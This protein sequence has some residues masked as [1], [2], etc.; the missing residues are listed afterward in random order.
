[1]LLHGSL[2]TSFVCACCL[3]RCFVKFEVVLAAMERSFQNRQSVHLTVNLYTLVQQIQSNVCISNHQKW[4]YA[5]ISYGE[6]YLVPNPPPQPV[7]CDVCDYAVEIDN[8]A[9]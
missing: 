5:A 1:M 9:M 4:L 7:V 6:R 8:L 3:C 2:A